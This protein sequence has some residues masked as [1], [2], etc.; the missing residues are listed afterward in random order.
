MSSIKSPMSC[1]EE[2]EKQQQ[3]FTTF[4]YFTMN[5]HHMYLMNIVRDSVGDGNSTLGDHSLGWMTG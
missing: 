2:I 1:V 3:R 4:K 5:V